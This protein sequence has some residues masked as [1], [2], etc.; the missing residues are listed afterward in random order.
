MNDA[1]EETR[2]DLRGVL[3]QI[4]GGRLLLPNACIAEILSVADP[5]PI[6]D[7]P[8]WLLGRVRWRG[9]QVPLVAFSRLIGSGAPNSRL[10]GER[11]LVLKALGGNPRM[12]YFAMLTQGFPRLVTVAPAMLQHGDDAH[13]DALALPVR[14][15]D[16]D[17]LIPDL[18]A[19]EDR[20][21]AVAAA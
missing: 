18:D 20:I 14:F 16:E 11:V 3:I 10:R 1:I 21:G 4:A 19:L 9:W 5:E 15:Q 12:P 7:A 17:V 6:A 2:A 8:D 13:T